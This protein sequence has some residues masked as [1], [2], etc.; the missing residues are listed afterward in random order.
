M[1]HLN[2]NNGRTMLLVTYF[3]V[4]LLTTAYFYYKT[5]D[6]ELFSSYINNTAFKINP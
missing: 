4:M 5:I 6:S 3:T 2:T 1:N